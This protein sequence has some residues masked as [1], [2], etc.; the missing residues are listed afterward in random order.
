MADAATTE[1]SLIPD[2]DEIQKR[3]DEA[4]RTKV[5]EQV[6]A[7]L[8][9]HKRK[10][11]KENEELKKKLEEKP[12]DVAPSAAPAPDPIPAP[13]DLKGQLELLEKK[14]ARAQEAWN[15]E[16][17]A[18]KAQ[19]NKERD[20]RLTTERDKEI[21]D[22]LTAAECKDMVGGRRYVTAQVEF[23]EDKWV[24]RTKK[25]NIVSIV[26]GV[27][28]ELPDYLRSAKMSNGGSGSSSGTAKSLAKIKLLEHEKKLLA[29]LKSKAKQSGQPADM[30]DFT[31][32]KKKI[33]AL[34]AER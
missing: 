30:V 33:E 25:D 18:L 10:L 3:I 17:M 31:R 26:E 34:E 19:A 29:E 22:A 32:Q 1:K 15:S 9:S 13:N 21:G 24:F 14:M 12:K 27:M 28:E 5:D 20:R 4:V 16:N 11:Q 2:L 23:D 7:V 8:A 6:N